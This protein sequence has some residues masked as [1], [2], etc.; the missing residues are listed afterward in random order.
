MC[1]FEFVQRIKIHNTLPLTIRKSERKNAN[2]T[3]SDFS[4][5]F[6]NWAPVRKRTKNMMFMKMSI[7]VKSVH[8]KYQGAIFR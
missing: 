6:C 7:T 3:N 2:K 5:G 4:L 1:V 8:Q